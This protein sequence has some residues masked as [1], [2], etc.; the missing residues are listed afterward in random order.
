MEAE[1]DPEE[2]AKAF[3]TMLDSA[4]K[5]LHGKTSVS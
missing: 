2:T 5:P 4:Q 1:E 3:Y